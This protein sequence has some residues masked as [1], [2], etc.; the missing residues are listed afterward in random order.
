MQQSLFVS[1]LFR[2]S[3]IRGLQTFPDAQ[4]VNLRIHFPN[5]LFWNY[6]QYI[7]GQEFPIETKLYISRNIARPV[8]HDSFVYTYIF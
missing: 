6:N 1:S 2:E 5:F 8:N 7:I 3:F 4:K